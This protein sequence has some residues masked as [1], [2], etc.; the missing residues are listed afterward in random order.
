VADYAW[1]R[2]RRD[3]ISC[4]TDHSVIAEDRDEPLDAVNAVL[5]RNHTGVGAHEWARLLTRHLGI[6]ELYGEQHHVDWSDLLRV[7]G[8]VDV[9]QMKVA[10][11]ALYLEAISTNCIAMRAARNE[12]HIMSSR[13][14]P[15]AEIT[16]HGTGCH[17]RDSHV[18]P[19]A[20]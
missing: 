2:D 12:R 8:D 1:P 17:D 4:P 9:L 10:K 6:P 11:G 16:S 15:P 3:N 5:K 13:S 14:Y 18:T 7:I 20:A 19:S